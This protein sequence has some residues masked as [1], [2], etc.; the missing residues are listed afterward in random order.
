MKRKARKPDA[1][2]IGKRHLLLDLFTKK[3]LG[4]L[5]LCIM[6]GFVLVAIFA[7]QL[8]PY[9][10][11]NG[12]F[13]TDIIHRLE[14]P[15]QSADHVFGTDALGRDLLSYCIY[16][17]RTSVILCFGCCLLSIL[18]SVVIGT[19]SAVI[20]GWFDL[21]LQRFVD[22]WQCIPSMLIMLIL[23]T[24]LGSGVPQ[25]IIALSVPSGIGGSRMIRSAALS[26]RNSGYVQSAELLGS[27]VLRKTVRHVVPNIM[28]LIIVSMAGSLGG[29]ILMEASLSFLGF[30]LGGSSASWGFIL[31]E[32][33]R[34]NMYIAPWLSTIPGALIAIMVFAANML[35][36]GVRDLLDPRLKGGVGSYRSKKIGKIVEKYRRR[37]Q[38]QEQKRS[39]VYNR[40]ELSKPVR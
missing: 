35:G 24:F 34:A 14:P 2:P 21:I 1:D 8:A 20:G 33:G 19:I 27:G 11:V 39:Y 4:G 26:I 12:K 3:P 36:D 23:I 31:T 15:F 16:G 28:P 40:E 10:L 25:L 7:D 13:Q 37:L 6:I 17:A 18:I 5:G 30:G 9:P 38:R 32:Q 29:V 22:A